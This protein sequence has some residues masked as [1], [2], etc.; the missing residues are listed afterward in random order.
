[1][2]STSQIDRCT[3][4]LLQTVVT[5]AVP[6]LPQFMLSVAVIVR[7]LLATAGGDYALSVQLNAN[8][9]LDHEI[10][11]Y[12]GTTSGEQTPGR[13]GGDRQLPRLVSFNRVE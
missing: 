5:I 9:G 10:A 1:L 11:C 13:G 7:E 8:A 3:T 4:A 2:T 6:Q 12:A